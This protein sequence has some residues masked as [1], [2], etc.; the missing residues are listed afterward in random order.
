MDD[1][2]VDELFLK[3]LD[4]TRLIREKTVLV[5]KLA[6]RGFRREYRK[7]VLEDR[8]DLECLKRKEKKMKFFFECGSKMV[9]GMCS[10]YKECVERCLGERKERVFCFENCKEAMIKVIEEAD[11]GRLTEICVENS[12]GKSEEGLNKEFSG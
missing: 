6:E 2:D 3:D 12:L 8:V 10:G 11:Y 1:E 4:I 9:F 7:C 5:E